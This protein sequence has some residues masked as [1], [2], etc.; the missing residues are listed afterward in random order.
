MLEQILDGPRLS[1]A[2]QERIDGLLGAGEPLD[3]IVEDT[4]EDRFGIVVEDDCNAEAATKPMATLLAEIEPTVP[5]QALLDPNVR[6]YHF[7]AWLPEQIAVMKLQGFAREAGGEIV[8]SVA[9]HIRL[10]MIDEQ[11]LATARSPGLLAWLGLVQE[12]DFRERVLAVL[13]LDLVHKPAPGRHMIGISLQITP[14]PCHNPGQRWN[15]YCDRLF[16]E[17]RAFLVGYQ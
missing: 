6:F 8:E 16:C 5:V 4:D 11:Y 3:L 15:V 9:G 12:R 14:G 1:A 2:A 10:Q 17:L 7:D 13:Q